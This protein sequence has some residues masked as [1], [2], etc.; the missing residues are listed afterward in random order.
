MFNISTINLEHGGHYQ[1]LK[2]KSFGYIEKYVRLIKKYNL[3][4][5]CFQECIFKKTSEY[6]PIDISAIIAK[7][8]G[9]YHKYNK[10]ADISI[11][12]EFSM[13]KI[14]DNK[15][16]FLTCLITINPYEKIIVS[17]IHLMDTPFTYY[18]L[19]G[20]PYIY[21][22]SGLNEK[23]SINLSYNARKQDLDKLFDLIKISEKK[24]KTNKSICCGDFNE[25]SHLDGKVKWKISS[26]LYKKKYTD[27]I[28][29]Y[30]PN[31]KKNPMYSCDID[32]KETKS[33]PPIRIDMLYYK[34][35]EPTNAFMI[36]NLFLSDHIPIVAA[37][38]I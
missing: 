35:M 10:K 1:Y 21:T 14:S 30:Y 3:H 5:V 4:V 22:P 13:K 23:Q 6:E 28:R 31:Y 17:N 7:K 12:S 19:I 32:R 34:N 16:D 25:L 20:P 27:V 38:N 26:R 9:F 2:T 24:Y 15:N 11:I 18:S 37:F 29:K 33:N 8:L 36:Y